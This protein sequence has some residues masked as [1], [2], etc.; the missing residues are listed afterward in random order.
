MLSHTQATLSKGDKW[1]MVSTPES[2]DSQKYWEK[3]LTPSQLKERI[4]LESTKI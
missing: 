1:N 2:K 3:F 4:K